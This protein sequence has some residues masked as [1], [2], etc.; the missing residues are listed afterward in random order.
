MSRVV[1]CVCA[2]KSHAA[3]TF[4]AIRSGALDWSRVRTDS[5]LGMEYVVRLVSTME[6]PPQTTNENLKFFTLCAFVDSEGKRV[7][8]V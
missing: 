5:S 4:C 7:E 1:V 6:Q 2:V 8:G 3:P